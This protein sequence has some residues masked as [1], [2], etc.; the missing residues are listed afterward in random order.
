MFSFDL[1]VIVESKLHKHPSPAIFERT[2]LTQLMLSTYATHP[3]HLRNLHSYYGGNKMAAP[4]NFFQKSVTVLV[5]HLHEAMKKK[6][7]MLKKGTMQ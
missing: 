4:H 1:H 3:L 6:K 2:S 5:F 7:T